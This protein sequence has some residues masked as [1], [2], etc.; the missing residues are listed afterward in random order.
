VVRAPAL[1]AHRS[2]LGLAA[3]ALALLFAYYWTSGWMPALPLWAD[4]VLISV[5]IVPL[6]FTLLWLALPLRTAR[7]LLVVAVALGILAV[8][9]Q[10]AGWYLA[11][12]LAKGL[13]VTALGFWFL[14]YF[15]RI[16]WVV[17]VAAVVPL[18]DAVSVWRGPTHHI[19]TERPRVFD[20][21]S[22][23]FPVPGERFIT[24][25]WDPPEAGEPARYH[26]YR[27]RTEGQTPRR[28]NR[29]PLPP[30]SEGFTDGNESTRR[31]YSYE[32]EAVSRGGLRTRSQ[33]VLAPEVGE[34]PPD[35]APPQSPT[36]PRPEA[37]ETTSTTFNL[38]LPDI[39][40]FALFLAAAARWHLRVAAT[41]AALLASFGVTVA[42]AIWVDPF[43]IEGLPALP[44]LSIAFLLANADLL[45]V[46][47]RERHDDVAETLG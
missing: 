16:S 8:T 27:A 3:A 25:R 47:L 39:L 38:G 11:S 37:A 34:E 7:G 46:R 18:V 10:S 40:F 31:A 29:R 33:R 4:V 35:P 1:L 26:V 2:R 24:L 22:V 30:D 45:L 23:G 15:E 5:A 21:L 6:G 41:W 20:A 14:S 43:G 32:I 19:V 44:G 13:A 9:W 17:L 36:E 28:I 42:L 12:G